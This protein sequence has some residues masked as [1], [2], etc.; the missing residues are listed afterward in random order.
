MNNVTNIGNAGL[1]QIIAKARDAAAN[2]PGAMSE[3]EKVVVALVLN[4]PDWLEAMQYTLA[5]AIERIGPDWARLVPVAA[6][7][8]NRESEA[9]T[10]ASAERA[11]T[12][13]LAQLAAH[14]A[15][16]EMMDFS[17]TLVTHGDAPGYRDVRLVFDL[18][19]IGEEPRPVIRAAIRVRPEDA[20]RIVDSI[21]DVHR[22]AWDQSNGGRPIDATPDEERPGWVD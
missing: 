4:R 18:E 15:G 7:Q 1:E 11:R 17:A 8:F 2:G 3:G 19:P 12:A 9:A 21:K 20:G 13:K 14:Q 22:F 10:Y 6:R 16:D 5:E